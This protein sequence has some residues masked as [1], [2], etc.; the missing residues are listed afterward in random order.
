VPLNRDGERMR[1][2]LGG[3]GDAVRS[4]GH[5]PEALAGTIDRLRCRLFTSRAAQPR[6]RR[7]VNLL[8]RDSVGGDVALVLLAVLDERAVA[9]E[10]SGRASPEGNVQHLMPRQM[11]S[12]G[13]P[14]AKARR[15]R[16]SRGRR[17]PRTPV[18]GVSA[19]A[20]P[21]RVDVAAREEKESSWFHSASRADPTS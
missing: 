15:V 19:L 18:Q 10:M 17:A 1:G 14:S 8:H 16:S 20:V 7:G 6:S 12:R 9:E 2:D 3:L 4:V 21:S 5:D 11:A 13:T